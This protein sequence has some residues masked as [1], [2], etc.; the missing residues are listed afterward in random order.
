MIVSIIIPCYNK[1]RFLE[2]ALNSVL[3]QI[4][5]QWECI[6][7]DDGST[8]NTEQIALNYTRLDS[9]FRYI[10]KQNQGVSATRNLG[11]AQATGNFIQF[12]DPDDIIYPNKISTQI[13]CIDSS[14]DDIVIY[15][16]YISS[17]ENDLYLPYSGDRYRS[18]FLNND[19][20][21]LQ[22]V[23]RW[24]KSLAIPIHCF[25]FSNTF[26][27]QKGIN[28]DTSLANHED[29]DCWLKI[30]ATNPKVIFVDEKLATYRISPTAMCANYELMKKG[31]LQ[32]IKNNIQFFKNI[33][34]VKKALIIKFFSVKYE[35][36]FDSKYQAHHYIFKMKY[37][38]LKKSVYRFF[39]KIIIKS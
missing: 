4:Y 22:L 1:G 38:E 2:D 11:L 8:D 20:Y 28:F 16:D 30:F 19:N 3:S 24:E 6:I 36:S 35:K 26:F 9:R 37:F 27:K 25:L 33:K 34:Q 32:S 23:N 10:K 31:H 13:G 14:A 17:E 7:I 12:L 39:K 18:P 29:W 15:C 21:L 5:T